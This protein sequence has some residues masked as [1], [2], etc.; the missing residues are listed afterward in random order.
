VGPGSDPDVAER[1]EISCRYR[2]LNSDSSVVRPVA[3][4][5][6]LGSV[7]LLC[8]LDPEAGCP[9]T[10]FVVPVSRGRQM[11]PSLRQCIIHSSPPI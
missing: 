1:R 8:V 11:L 2:K 5:Q 10:S 6:Y 7:L 9:D 3:S 4:I